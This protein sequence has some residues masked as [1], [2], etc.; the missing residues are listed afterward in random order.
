MMVFV[1]I[2]FVYDWQENFPEIHMPNWQFYLQWAVGQWDIYIYI[3]PRASKTVS[4]RCGFGE[5][6]LVD[7]IQ[8][9]LKN[10]TFG[11]WASENF[12]IHQALMWYCV[13]I[14]H[15]I[16]RFHCIISAWPSWAKEYCRCNLSVCLPVCPVTLTLLLL[17]PQY[18]MYLIHTWYSHWPYHDNTLSHLWNYNI[19]WYLPWAV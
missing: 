7:H 18:F 17:R 11:S 13:I 2:Q 5:S 3:Y 12:R 4:W 19:P 16:M 9:V 8:S 14:N 1:Y 6:F 10:K 15:V